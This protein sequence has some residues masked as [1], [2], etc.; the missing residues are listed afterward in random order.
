MQPLPLLWIVVSFFP[1]PVVPIRR[2]GFY[3]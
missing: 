3:I 1:S 2:T